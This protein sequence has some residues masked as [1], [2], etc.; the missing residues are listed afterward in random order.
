MKAI[1]EHGG[2][3]L[4]AYKI[5]KYRNE[6]DYL[7][8]KRKDKVQKQICLDLEFFNSILEAISISQDEETLRFEMNKAVNHREHRN[9]YEKKKEFKYYFGTFD[10]LLS[11]NMDYMVVYF[12]GNANRLIYVELEWKK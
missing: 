8:E 7:F 12:E 11:E 10:D 1:I 4:S 3:D 6:T 5:S 2:L 9:R